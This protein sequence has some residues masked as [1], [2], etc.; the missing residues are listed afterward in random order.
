[1]KLS[2][3]YKVAKYTSTLYVG[4]CWKDGDGCGWRGWISTMVEYIPETIVDLETLPYRGPNGQLE[5]AK[6][7]FYR[8]F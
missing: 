8:L 1:M 4:E 7:V 3:D 2:I 6:R 5:L